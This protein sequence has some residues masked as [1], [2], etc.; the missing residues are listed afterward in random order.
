MFSL[1][2]MY[3]ST[4]SS[5]SSQTSLPSTIHTTPPQTTHLPTLSPTLE[6]YLNNSAPFPNLDSSVSNK[7]R[8]EILSSHSSIGFLP[9][10]STFNPEYFGITIHTGPSTPEYMFAYRTDGVIIEHITE[11][12]PITLR[13]GLPEL[14]ETDSI[15]IELDT[16]HPS[17]QIV[18]WKIGDAEQYTFTIPSIFNS[19][20][21][22]YFYT[23]CDPRFFNKSTQSA[24]PEDIPV[25]CN[26]DHSHPLSQVASQI[27][28]S[29]N[30]VPNGNSFPSSF[31]GSTPSQLSSVPSSFSQTVPSPSSPPSPTPPSGS[32]SPSQI[33]ILGYFSKMEDGST[34]DDLWNYASF[35]PPTSTE[36]KSDEH[37]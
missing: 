24:Q 28:P 10:D 34:L 35:T 20:K 3:D 37:T 30:I 2:Q 21:L 27:A 7:V 11:C 1:P 18:R 16:S 5:S 26:T 25:S 17:K 19:L 13:Y 4:S 12:I 15:W 31:S 22:D 23:V 32:H 8:L 14:T 33:K 6:K 9:N 36:E 29:Y